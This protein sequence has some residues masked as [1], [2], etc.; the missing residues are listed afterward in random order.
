MM[1][2]NFH[3]WMDSTFKHLS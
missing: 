1:P 3:F 2:C